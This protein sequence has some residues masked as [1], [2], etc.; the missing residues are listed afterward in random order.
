MN[1]LQKNYR[2]KNGEKQKKKHFVL[3][4]QFPL[5]LYVLK[6]VKEGRKLIGKRRKPGEN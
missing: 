5:H 1:P 4:Q 2:K 6:I 3:V